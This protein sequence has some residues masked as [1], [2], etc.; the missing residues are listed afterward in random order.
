MALA[1]ASNRSPRLTEGLN[2]GDAEERRCSKKKSKICTDFSEN[3][4]YAD[5]AEKVFQDV[6]AAFERDE[7][8]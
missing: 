6:N 4:E 5:L 3:S 7:L 1:K 8:M 2:Q